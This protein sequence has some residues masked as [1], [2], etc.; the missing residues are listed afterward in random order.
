MALDDKD[1]HKDS[2]SNND[3]DLEVCVTK[4]ELL[5]ILEDNSKEL[6]KYAKLLRRLSREYDRVSA[7]LAIAISKIESLSVRSVQVVWQ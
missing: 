1:E 3:T 2:N 5:E 6:K 7:E 4:D